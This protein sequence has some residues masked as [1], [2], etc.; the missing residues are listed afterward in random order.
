MVFAD[1]QQESAPIHVRSVDEDYRSFIEDA[2]RWIENENYFENASLVNNWYSVEEGETILA[3]WSAD[4]CV[5]GVVLADNGQLLVKSDDDPYDDASYPNGCSWVQCYF[6]SASGVWW[7]KV[8]VKKMLLVYDDFYQHFNSD[9]RAFGKE[10]KESL[11]DLIKIITGKMEVDIGGADIVIVGQDDDL[12]EDGPFWQDLL[13]R[14]VLHDN[15]CAISR[16]N[17]CVS[18]TFEGDA[19]LSLRNA[20][21]EIRQEL[22]Y[23]IN[24]ARKFLFKYGIVKVEN[25]LD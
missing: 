18:G 21:N 2:Y 6:D 1:S 10:Q 7:L 9:A 11:D 16:E 22:T 12:A 17:A 20:L 19:S 13:M 24:D 8:A 3:W 4:T 23:Q 14:N 15:Y 25:H 5:C